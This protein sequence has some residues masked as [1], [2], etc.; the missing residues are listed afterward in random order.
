MSNGRPQRGAFSN[1]SKRRRISDI[2]TSIRAL[3]R[4]ILVL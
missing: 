3:T 4:A 2:S 1:R